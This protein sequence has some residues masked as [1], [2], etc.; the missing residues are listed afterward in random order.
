MLR[1]QGDLSLRFVDRG[2][3]NDDDTDTV[4]GLGISGGYGVTD[5]LE[6]GA[7]Y[8]FRLSPDG[9]LEGPLLLY[10]EYKFLDGSVDVAGTGGIIYDLASESGGLLL[11]AELQFE[12]GDMF[13]IYSPGY[14]LF[15]GMFNDGDTPIS[16][17]LP[18]GIR[19]QFTE[20][21]L[22]YAQVTLA[23]IGIKDSGDSDITDE[24][25]LL[26]GMFYSVSNK[27]DLGAALAVPDSDDIGVILTARF[28]F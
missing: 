19:L 25:N 9:D 1:L 7:G 3:P 13:A 6:L 24:A 2:G 16:I 22:G 14:Q 8:G 23:T 20:Q 21:I 15:I 5:E 4:I 26:V 12:I 17:A 11:G 18:I 28:F 10:G 27:L